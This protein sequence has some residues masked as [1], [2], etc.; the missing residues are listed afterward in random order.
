VRVGLATVLLVAVYALTLAS[1]HPLDL[2][3]GGLLAAALLTALRRFLFTGEPLTRPSFVRRIV[4]F[5]RFALA[6]AWEVARGTWLVGLVVIGRRPLV[7]PG[8]VC[9]PVGERTLSGV[10]V[11]ALAATLSPGEVFVDVDWERGVMLLHVLDAGDPDAV[12][13]HHAAIYDRHQRSVFP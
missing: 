10:A 11:T 9:I 7:Q 13:R 6:A 2:L 1:A 12:R 4:S 5:P 8:I 3:A